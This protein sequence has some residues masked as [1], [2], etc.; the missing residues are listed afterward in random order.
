MKIL[1][2]SLAIVLCFVLLCQ[3]LPL[4]GV[5]VAK[6]ASDAITDALARPIPNGEQSARP[7]TA[8]EAAKN[9]EKQTDD[10]TPIVGEGESLR[11]ESVKYFRHLDGTFTAATYAE[12]V[13]YLLSRN[14]KN[15]QKCI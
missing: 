1:A 9:P 15:R 7:L 5:A 8:A 11:E 10:P 2:R 4:E 3:T 12:P 13:H 6:P 14:C